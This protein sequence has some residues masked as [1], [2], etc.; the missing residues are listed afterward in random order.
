MTACEQ[1]PKQRTFLFLDYYS[2]GN[3]IAFV[4]KQRLQGADERDVNSYLE[5]SVLRALGEF[6]CHEKIVKVPY[7]I[8][9]DGNFHHRGVAGPIL[10]TYQ[11]RVP[12]LGAGSREAAEAYGFEQIQQMLIVGQAEIALWLSPPSFGLAGFG[13]Y[14]FLFVFVKKNAGE[15][16]E[17]V[18]RYND[19]DKAFSR[20]IDIYSKLF[21][22]AISLDSRTELNDEKSFLRN[23]LFM[24][25]DDPHNTFISI[26]KHLGFIPAAE[27]SEL[28]QKIEAD[29]LIQTWIK[30]YINFIL[31]GVED[32]A[33]QYLQAIYNRARALRDNEESFYE[34]DHYRHQQI[35]HDE[36]VLLY[37]SQKRA[38]VEGGG[39]CPAQV[40]SNSLFD[41]DVIEVLMKN[42]GIVNYHTASI[43]T[44]SKKN[45]DTTIIECT[46]PICNQKVKAEV[47]KKKIRCPNC[48]SVR[49]YECG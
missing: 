15:I 22:Q 48:K 29:S 31:V 9:D 34:R 6:I 23:P 47:R 37:Y 25:T 11:Q 33:Q 16:D 38:T 45:T 36:A 7:K 20:S 27:V 10:E 12:N 40:D 8:H 30:D 32:Q 1:E 4:N 17:Y 2:V 35:I 5:D 41:S 26:C 43:I 18:L 13:D 28:M 42:D 3:E 49:D 39:S 19:E 44:E 46:C 24:K 14:G 21:D